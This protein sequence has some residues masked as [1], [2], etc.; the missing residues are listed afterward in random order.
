MRKAIAVLVVLLLAFGGWWIYASYLLQDRA[1]RLTSAVGDEILVAGSELPTDDEIR[2]AIDAR[3]RELGAAIVTLEIRSEA[4]EREAPESTRGRTG[5]EKIRD[6]LQK[7]RVGMR[8]TRNAVSLSAAPAPTVREY[9]VH[10]EFVVSH[11]LWSQR[12]PLDVEKV[13]RR[14]LTR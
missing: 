3:A 6:R 12:V 1:M 8:P 7:G 11:G 2:D 4:I 9:A 5:L 13:L 14:Q 10:G